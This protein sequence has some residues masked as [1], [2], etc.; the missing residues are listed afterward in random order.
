[1]T[2]SSSSLPSSSSSLSTSSHIHSPPP[3]SSPFLLFS[4]HWRYVLLP[5]LSS[6]R[7]IANL[8]FIFLS[9]CLFIAL[10]IANVNSI[11]STHFL[12]STVVVCTEFLKLFF[13][14]YLSYYYDGQQNWAL[15]KEC[16]VRAF[17]D[18]GLDILKLCLPAILYTIQNNL[19]YII[20]SAPLFLVLYQSKI[21]TTAIFFTVMLSKRLSIKEWCAILLLAI[22]VSIVES[23]Q[24]DISPNHHASSIVGFFSVIIAILTSGFAGVYFEKVLKSS[25]SSIWIINVQLSMM[26]CSFSMMFAMVLDP[27][28]IMERGLFQGFNVIVLGILIL[29]A[30]TGLALALVVKYSDNL[31]KGFGNSI[32]IVIANFFIGLFYQDVTLNVHF[33]LGSFLVAASSAAYYALTSNTN[34]TT[35]QHSTSSTVPMIVSTGGGNTNTGGT[36]SGI[37]GS[38]LYNLYSTAG[39]GNVNSQM[40]YGNAYVVINGPSSFNNVNSSNHSEQTTIESSTSADNNILYHLKSEV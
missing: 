24:H 31:Y 35:S 30:V 20:E 6:P 13:S 9:S 34:P 21:V 17:I 8:S 18:D 26:S 25:R 32:A 37:A 23:S 22:G 33:A 14:I 39:S 7:W 29:Q 27:D 12:P 1:M 15:F 36:S 11:H 19:Q 16:L 3:S 5:H 28:A 10:H 2:T 40:Q 38:G 4:H